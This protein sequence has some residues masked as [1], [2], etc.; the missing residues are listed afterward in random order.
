MLWVNPTPSAGCTAGGGMYER[1]GSR[2]LA[3]LMPTCSAPK[4]H[5]VL[6]A[7]SALT[8]LVHAAAA[9]T[10][11]A[12]R[13]W[14]NKAGAAMGRVGIEPTTLG[15]KSRRHLLGAGDWGVRRF[16]GG[17]VPEWRTKLGSAPNTVHAPTGLLLGDF[18]VVA[19]CGSD[20]SVGTPGGQSGVFKSVVCMCICCRRCAGAASPDSVFL[21]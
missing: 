9:A 14:L 8:R 19:R 17:V 5:R 13:G 18:T 15:L 20:R 7:G 2:P 11:H 21:T 16:C 1:I 3:A 12:G 4:G 10:S 6:K